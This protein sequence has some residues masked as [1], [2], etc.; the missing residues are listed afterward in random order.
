M[1]CVNNNYRIGPRRKSS[2]DNDADS[3]TS[4]ILNVIHQI[5]KSIGLGEI[6]Q[7]NM[8]GVIIPLFWTLSHEPN[9]LIVVTSIEAD[10]ALAIT[11]IEIG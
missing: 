11:R 3:N 2:S 10:P 8:F 1:R 9:T 4:R 6:Y 7:G 5:T